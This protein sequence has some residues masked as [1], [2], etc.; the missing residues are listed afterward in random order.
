MGKE[1]VTMTQLQ[2]GVVTDEIDQD[3][4][5]ACQVA[6]ELDMEVVEMNSIWGKPVDELEPAEVNQVREIVRRH[7]LRIDVIGTLALK[8]LEF[9]K[10]PDLDHSEKFAEHLDTVRRA[11]R[12]ARALAD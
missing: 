11:A 9:G 6:R 2:L 10:N 1:N 7:E 5:R 12:I 3:L 8:G 4:E